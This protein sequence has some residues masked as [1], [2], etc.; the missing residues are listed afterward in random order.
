MIAAVAAARRLDPADSKVFDAVG[1]RSL[2]C[3]LA[4]GQ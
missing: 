2:G 1:G 3:A 4:A